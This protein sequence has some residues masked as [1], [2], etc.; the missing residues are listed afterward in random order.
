M[1]DNN[2]A[3]GV[4]VSTLLADGNF[5]KKELQQTIP[6]SAVTLV[7]GGAIVNGLIEKGPSNLE[8]MSAN[9]GNSSTI[10][11]SNS[12]MDTSSDVPLSKSSSTIVNVD[13]APNSKTAR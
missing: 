10:I 5:M 7:S 6:T 12:A 11:Q 3:I 2:Q 8:S 4:E 1:Q 13:T 9:M